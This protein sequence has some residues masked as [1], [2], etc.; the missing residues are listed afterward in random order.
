MTEKRELTETKDGKIPV[1]VLWVELEQSLFMKI[2]SKRPVGSSDLLKF[3]N[4]KEGPQTVSVFEIPIYDRKIG[5]MPGSVITAKMS[6]HF[7]IESIQRTSPHFGGKLRQNIKRLLGILIAW[8][9]L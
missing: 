7:N 8:V 3:E 5:G 6:S 4:S 2:E 9:Q 1:E